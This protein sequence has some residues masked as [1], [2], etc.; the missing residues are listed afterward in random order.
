MDTK[1]V[2]EEEKVMFLFSK[3]CNVN[4]KVRST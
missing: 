2:T 1:N 3:S 4:G